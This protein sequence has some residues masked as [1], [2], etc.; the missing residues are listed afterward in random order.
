MLAQDG[1]WLSRS[2]IGATGKQ[3]KHMLLPIQQIYLC[4]Q[5]GQALQS[6]PSR[7]QYASAFHCAAGARRALYGLPIRHTINQLVETLQ[8]LRIL[9]EKAHRAID[10][11]AQRSSASCAPRQCFLAGISQPMAARQPRPA[12]AALARPSQSA[13]RATMESPGPR[14]N[15]LAFAGL[16]ARRAALDEGISNTR[17]RVR[18]NC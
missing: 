3:T 10:G 16:D 8:L 6:S 13:E 2:L 5:G 15:G 11:S 17:K 4:M 12:D 9:Y 1:I 14:K 18:S 7:Y